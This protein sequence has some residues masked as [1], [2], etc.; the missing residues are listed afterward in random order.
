[1]KISFFLFDI[2]TKTEDLIQYIQKEGLEEDLRDI[3]AEVWADVEAKCKVER[4]NYYE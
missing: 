4:L 2:K 3:V 1:M